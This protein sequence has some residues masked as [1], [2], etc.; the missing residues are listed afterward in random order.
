MAVAHNCKQRAYISQK[1]AVAITATEFSRAERSCVLRGANICRTM[2]RRGGDGDPAGNFP[3]ASRN[4]SRRGARANL[5]LGSVAL[6]YEGLWLL[7]SAEGTRQMRACLYV[8]LKYKRGGDSWGH[9]CV[10]MRRSSHAAAAAADDI[11]KLSL[12]ISHTL[13]VYRAPRVLPATLRY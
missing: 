8:R 2:S 12:P 9:G 11:S 6:N 4:G 3:R 7:I 10:L 13:P 5:A 1:G